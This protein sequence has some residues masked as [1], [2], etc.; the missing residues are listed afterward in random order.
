MLS[1][2]LIALAMIFAGIALAVVFARDVTR[3][4]DPPPLGWLAAALCIVGIGGVVVTVGRA[5]LQWW[6][7]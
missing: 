5:A 4:D 7:G 3:A 2:L 1:D 6:V